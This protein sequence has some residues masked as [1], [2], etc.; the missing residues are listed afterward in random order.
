MLTNLFGG[1]SVATLKQ[2]QEAV[3]DVFTET[4]NKL[5]VINEE[6]AKEKTKKDEEIAR[7]QNDMLILENIEKKNKVVIDNINKILQ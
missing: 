7:L 2:K 6:V 5:K 1:D 3:L 4:Q